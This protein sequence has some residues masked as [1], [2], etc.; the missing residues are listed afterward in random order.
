MDELF[1]LLKDH[2][3]P[4]VNVIAE[5]FRF[6]K[7]QQRE[8]ESI[9]VYLSELRR[10]ARNCQFGEQLKISLRDQLVCGLFQETVQQKILAESDL[11]LEQALRIAQAAETAQLETQTL[12]GGG[13]TVSAPKQPAETAF[14]IKKTTTANS[15]PGGPGKVL[16]LQ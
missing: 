15:Q 12:R 9:A 5:R 1:Q 6:F 10:L 4:K 8:G 13:M 2:Y 7:R 16:S 14:A 3:E 11:T